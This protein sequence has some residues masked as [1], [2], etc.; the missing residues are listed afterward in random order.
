[1]VSKE[2]ESSPL[3]ANINPSTAT[4]LNKSTRVLTDIFRRH[5]SH[6]KATLLLCLQWTND[7]VGAI[8]KG[9]MESSMF[10]HEDMIDLFSSVITIAGATRYE[11]VVLAAMTLLTTLALHSSVTPLKILEAAY[12]TA[13]ALASSTWP[14]VVQLSLRFVKIMPYHLVVAFSGADRTVEI[15]DRGERETS[16]TSNKP[17]SSSTSSKSSADFSATQALKRH[18]MESDPQYGTFRALDFRAVMGYILFGHLE[19]TVEDRQ[20]WLEWLY[21]SCNKTVESIGNDFLR[22]D[23]DEDVDDENNNHG[24]DPSFERN[25][26]FLWNWACWE[27][28]R[29]CIV[30]KLRSP[31]GKALDTF[32]AV[33]NVLKAY[34]FQLKQKCDEPEKESG[35]GNSN[36]GSEATSWLRLV[37]S[38]QRRV[39]ALLLFVEH[40]EKQLYN[41]FEG[42]A[43]ALPAPNKLVKTFFR[44]NKSSCQEWVHRNR[45]TLMIV[46]L[47]ADNPHLT[48]WHGNEFLRE[49]VA[50]NNAPSTAS[51]SLAAQQQ[52]NDHLE[53]ALILYVK[54]LISVRAG[55]AVLGLYFWCKKALGK[56]FSWIRCLA[57]KAGG[58]EEQS[59]Q[60]I[61]ALLQ[62]WMTAAT[63]VEK[64]AAAATTTTTTTTTTIAKMTT[65]TLSTEPDGGPADERRSPGDQLLE[66]LQSLEQGSLFTSL[67]MDDDDDDVGGDKNGAAEEVEEEEEAE[68]IGG[69]SDWA[70]AKTKT[71]TLAPTRPLAFLGEEL[72]DSYLNVGDWSQFLQWQRVIKEKR[73]N[74]PSSLPMIFCPSSTDVSYVSALSAFSAGDYAEACRLLSG[75]PNEPARYGLKGGKGFGVSLTLI[76]FVSRNEVQINNALMVFRRPMNFLYQ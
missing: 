46:S 51:K 4:H 19:D 45:V 30:N 23:E 17:T 25:K 41:A 69:K 56:K 39:R 48:L 61:A 55:A 76:A 63:E 43:S 3:L 40:L 33:E 28:A 60:Q 14:E 32:I 8:I 35:E 74:T 52:Q 36:G 7:I 42:C 26:V 24:R 10:E 65:S 5:A 27:T 49:F 37:G 57:D 75:E 29:F 70:T 72:L 68:E 34:A 1:M 6:G 66:S 12:K 54:A 50:I 38:K 11:D 9:Q 53:L 18:V 16:P 44:T 71:T 15:G 31:L 73:E 13:T 20:D 62:P 67:G 47:G 58:Q 21:C 64:T 22:Y 2:R 59:S